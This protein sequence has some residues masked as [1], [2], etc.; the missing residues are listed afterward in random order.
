MNIVISLSTP[1][2]W[3]TKCGDSNLFSVNHLAV[4]RD[5]D[6]PVPVG[7]GKKL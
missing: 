6:D 5:D 7:R 1:S 4:K 2:A 3:H